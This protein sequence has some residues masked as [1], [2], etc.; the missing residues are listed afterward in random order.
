[1]LSGLG[2]SSTSETLYTFEA[3]EEFLKEEV[4]SGKMFGQ[5]WLDIEDN[6]S[7]GCSWYSYSTSS[8]CEFLQELISAVQSHGITVGVYTSEY[9]WEN[10]MGS[11]SACPEASSV[12]LW[13]AH[14]DGSRT[15]SDYVR[16]GGWSSPAIKQFLGDRSA[17]GVGID[18]NWY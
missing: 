15:F 3:G 1:M 10:T 2:V 8:N 7:S 6:P 17:C 4:G 18:L 5:V 14:Y 12:Q 9:E 16:I 11:L 13:Y